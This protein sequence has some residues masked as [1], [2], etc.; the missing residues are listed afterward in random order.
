MDLDLVGQQS[1][2][3][4]AFVPPVSIED[5]PLLWTLVRSQT[6]YPEHI[7]AYGSGKTCYSLVMGS[8]S[9]QT[10]C[11]GELLGRRS[12]HHT[13]VGPAVLGL[14]VLIWT[15]TGPLDRSRTGWSCLCLRYKRDVCFLVPN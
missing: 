10:D 12:K 2:A 9:F 11:Y 6:Y 1:G 15:E 14:G 4:V 3:L 13:E 5:R 7:L 8:G